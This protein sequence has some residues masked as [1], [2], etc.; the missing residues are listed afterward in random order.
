[1]IAKNFMETPSKN[2]NLVASFEKNLKSEMKKAT[3]R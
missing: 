3:E 1:M 2:Q